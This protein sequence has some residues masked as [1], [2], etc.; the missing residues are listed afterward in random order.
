MTPYAGCL[1]LSYLKFE[2]L[3][4]LPKRTGC[5]KAKGGGRDNYLLQTYDI[6][7]MIEIRADLLCVHLATCSFES[8]CI[9]TGITVSLA[10]QFMLL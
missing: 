2:I 3:K 4:K 9:T 7:K 8:T 1:Y 6:F 10:P 5:L